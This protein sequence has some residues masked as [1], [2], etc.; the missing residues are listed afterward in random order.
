MKALRYKN[1]LI[2][3]SLLV[4]SLAMGLV[5]FLAVQLTWYD[6]AK[7]MQR[8]ALSAAADISLYVQ[9]RTAGQTPAEARAYFEQN[10]AAL[11]AAATAFTPAELE[12]ISLEGAPLAGKA[13]VDAQLMTYCSTE[14]EPAVLLK[15]VNGQ[16]R[17]QALVPVTGTDASLGYAGFS[18][19]TAQADRFSERLLALLAL[20]FLIG[21]ALLSLLSARFSRSFIEPIRDLTHISSEIN[22]GRYDVVIQYKKDDEIGDLTAVYNQ[23]IQN[24]NSVI[25]QLSSERK[26]LGSVLASLDD[27]LLALNQKGEVIASNSYLKTY[28]GVSNPKTIYDFKYQSFLRDIFDALRLGKAHVSEEVDC[29]GRQLLLTGSPIKNPGAEE[30]YMIIIRNVTATRTFEREQ[31]KFISSVSHELRT[32]LTTIIG[33]TDMLSRRQ[34]QDPALLSRSLETINKEGHR[35]VRL[36]DDLLNANSVETMEFTVRKALIS[37]DELLHSVVDQMRIKCWQKEIEITYKAVPSLPQIFGDYDR[38]SQIFINIIHNAMKYSSPG[39]IIEVVL[40]REEQDYLSVS[41]RDYG[42]GIDPA[43]KDFI[44]SAFYRVDEDRARNNGEGGAGLG[45]YLVKQVVE[46]HDGKIRVDSE[47]GEGTNVTILLPVPEA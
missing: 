13:Q 39:G 45:L 24:I 8:G 12:L 23:M 26:R 6:A 1:K 41:I 40:T 34:V 30:N 16:K 28:F 9:E 5:I 35:L 33:Y 32:P 19:A 21:L 42:T 22:K 3:N 46:K 36:V 11:C 37:L 10:A 14:N 47:L 29:G 44:F 25:L 2:L 20:S 27:G 31:Q 18:F 43:K 15:T 7:D 38:L 4:F 17:L